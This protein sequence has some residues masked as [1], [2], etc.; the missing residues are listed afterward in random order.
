MGASVP[1]PGA[2]TGLVANVAGRN[3]S[4]AWVAPAGPVTGYLLEYGGAEGLTLS[5]IPL[6]PTTVFAANNAPPG[7]F[8]VRVRA[9]NA[10]GVGP[11]TLDAVV[12][13][14]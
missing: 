3:V 2:P 12:V 6:G 10:A 13:V 5:S 4:L 7:T 14:P 11:P 8:Y 1:L 9:V